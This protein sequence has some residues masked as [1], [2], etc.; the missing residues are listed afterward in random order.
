MD[1]RKNLWEYGFMEGRLLGS[2][3]VNKS[4]RRLYQRKDVWKK[5]CIVGR[6]YSWKDV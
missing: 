4:G 6:L 5:K 1:G 3:V 2:M